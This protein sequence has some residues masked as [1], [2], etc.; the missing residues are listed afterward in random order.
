[1]PLTP[2]LTALARSLR[3]LQHV[4]IV[5]LIV[6]G[7]AWATSPTVTR[8]SPS[9]VTL[10]VGVASTVRLT[11]SGSALQDVVAVTVVDQRG[12][13]IAGISAR[14]TGSA[15]PSQRTLEI[16]G[17]GRVP[18]ASGHRL[19]LEVRGAK[20]SP[21]V[22]TTIDL[23]PTLVQVEV[24]QGVG[25]GGHSHAM[26][27]LMSCI[28][29]HDLMKANVANAYAWDVSPVVP[30]DVATYGLATSA[31]GATVSQIV[32]GQRVA[33]TDGQKCTACHT[34]PPNNGATL[35]LSATTTSQYMCQ[36]VPVFIQKP[37]K[38]QGLKN[39]FQ[40]WKD[41]NCP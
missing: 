19:R 26:T 35:P 32:R 10:Y 30:S 23:P 41:R 9:R 39:F 25:F 7:S 22:A 11:L 3:L 6:P 5:A 14:L 24:S 33:R 34:N 20:G 29:C 15:S 27:Q 36:I 16:S 13:A 1:M 18:V 21:S 17:D 4:T 12:A 28:A 2:R 8:A 37:G 31:M 38:P 40:N